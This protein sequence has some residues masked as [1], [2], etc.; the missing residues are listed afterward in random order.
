MRTTSTPG[1]FA[2]PTSR[3]MTDTL[4][5]AAGLTAFVA[6]FALVAMYPLVVGIGVATTA[7]AVTVARGLFAVRR[8]RR[9]STEPTETPVRG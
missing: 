6:L 4:L 3:S 5:D 1:A 8:T 7:V 9:A 2:R